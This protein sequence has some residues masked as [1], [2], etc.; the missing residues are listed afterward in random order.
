MLFSR[1]SS[2]LTLAA[3][4]VAPRVAF[5]QAPSPAAIADYEAKLKK[6]EQARAAYDAVADTYWD[7]VTEKRR[8]RNAKR[9]ERVAV[10]IDD[11][12]LTQPPQYSGPP[13]PADPFGR[14]PPSEQPPI[15]VIA[16]FLKAAADQFGFVPDRPQND[17]DFKRAYARAGLAAGLTREQIIGVYAFETGGNGTYDMQAG[18]T[19]TR[20]NAISPA[21]GYNQL[22]ST[23]TVSL[24][25]EFG[26]RYLAAL[27]MKA[28]PMRGEAKRVF[29]RKIEAF[30]R[31][32]AYSRSVPQRWSEQD[33]LAKTT[34]GGWGVHA[35]VL[36]IDIGPMLQVQKLINSV[37]FAKMKGYT[38]P[39][40][41]AELE[42]MNLT[43]DGNGFDIVSMPHA[44]RDRVPTANFFQQ[45]G[46]E[47]NPVARRTG[48]VANLLADMEAKM[49]R[50]AQSPGAR[51]LA[52][53]F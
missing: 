38:A 3:C 35:A 43:G 4:L 15:P 22:L 5:A 32:I 49:A 47:R 9:R 30:K 6:Y 26:E 17:A 33:K 28:L 27:R 10:T 7:Q 37:H 1:R 8:T 40:T 31:M 41:P 18:V 12:V 13:R 24:L 36:D 23:N 53:A 21:V 50:G 11:Y 29:E 48:V 25:A 19:P 42:A 2:C 20:P 46:Y 51:E 34:R 14:P 39:L 44:Y 45:R 16:D 52:S